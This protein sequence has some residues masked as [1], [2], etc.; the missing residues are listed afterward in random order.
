MFMCGGISAF[1]EMGIVHVV[2]SLCSDPCP[3]LSKLRGPGRI[4]KATEV[5]LF[6]LTHQEPILCQI[7]TGDV[8]DK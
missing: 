3:L 8:F 6:A 2:T 1:V 5:Q 7:E 4:T